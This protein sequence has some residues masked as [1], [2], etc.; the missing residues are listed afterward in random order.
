MA[1]NRVGFLCLYQRDNV[2]SQ[3]FNPRIVI[4][5]YIRRNIDISIKY[6]VIFVS[7]DF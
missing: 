7:E 1:N 2:K 4:K 6:F 3:K 5:A